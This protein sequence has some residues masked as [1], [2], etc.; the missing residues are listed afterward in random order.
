MA[1]LVI[2]LIGLGALYVVSNK[3]KNKPTTNN[4]KFT[5]MG[6]DENNLPNT[7][8]QNKNFPVHIQEIDK[9]SENYTRQY[10]NPNQTTDKFFNYDVGLNNIETNEIA[11][12]FHSLS[13]NGISKGDFK[14]NNMVP[15]FG[16]KITGPQINNN[17]GSTILD[18]YQGSGSIS[19]KKTEQAPLFK[20][21]DHTQWSHGVPNQSDFLQ[22][23]QL[24]S[25]KMANTLPWEQ[26]KVAP[27]LGLGYTTEGAGGFNSGMLDRK[28]WQPPTVDELR[29]AT[30]PKVTYGLQGHQGPAQSSVQNLPVQG[31]VEKHTP[32]TAFAMGSDRWFTTTGSSLGATQIPEQMLGNVN[33]CTT[34]YY[35][36]G[37]TVEGEVSYVNNSHTE[38]P[39]KQQLCSLPVTVPASQG[40][41]NAGPNDYGFKG[42][43]IPKNNR[44]YSCE[45]Q[46]NGV[47]GG[48]NSTFKAMMAPIV[49]ALRPSRKENIIYNANQLGNI[50]SAVPSLPLT[51]PND[52][53]RTT[54]K[55]MT[56]GKVGLNYLNI[57]HAS[58]G[59]GGAHQVTDVQV[60]G[61]QRNIGDSSTSGNIGNTSSTSAQ[62]DVTAW[63]AQHN[64]INKTYENWPM[65]GGTQIFQP[66]ANVQVARRDGD[67]VNNRMQCDDF[68]QPEKN[69]LSTTIP[70]AE[71][72][73][74]INMP[75]Q[76]DL[77][78]NSNRINPDI[79]S[80]FK[81]NPYAQSLNSY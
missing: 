69:L 41:G 23:R 31:K 81:S 17:I 11:R 46:N 64:N 57:S 55:E 78:V 59:Q 70:S 50:Q 34:Q 73:G 47:V 52:K 12:E 49:D 19:I 51:N 67:R 9:T 10:I 72:F 53:P 56:A 8:I 33:K 29:V 74:K 62:M 79:L 16:G 22:S 15:F 21:Q 65:A 1:E 42:Y 80:A 2:P 24:P 44:H 36:S 18:N 66:N 4:E 75:Q 20:P 58:A 25:T 39:H 60:R 3:D 5:N 43:N 68:I 6:K 35:G 32:D 45:S 63:N 13:G 26:E 27:G 40:H 37:G 28:A 30:N 54:N 38:E 48:I 7:H 76:Y 71:T 14:H 77:E 61:Q